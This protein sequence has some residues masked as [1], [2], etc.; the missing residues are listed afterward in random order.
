ML[1]IIKIVTYIA[2]FAFSVIGWYLLLEFID[3]VIKKL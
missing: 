1:S 2:L 3:Y